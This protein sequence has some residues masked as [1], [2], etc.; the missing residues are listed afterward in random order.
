MVKSRLRDVLLGLQLRLRL[1]L[2]LRRRRGR[3]SRRRRSGR[4][5]DGGIGWSVTTRGRRNLDKLRW[6]RK[7][8]WKRRIDLVMLGLNLVMGSFVIVMNDR[9]ILYHRKGGGRIREGKLVVRI[10]RN[11]LL[12]RDGHVLRMRSQVHRLTGFRHQIHDDFRR[13]QRYAE[14]EEVD[15]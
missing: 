4:E 10:E 2:R 7:R 15:R 8:R 1:G 14:M 3:L 13:G 6:R 12:M 5:A 11:L 9:R